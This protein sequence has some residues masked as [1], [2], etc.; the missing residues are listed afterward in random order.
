MHKKNGIQ[1]R[2][3]AYQILKSILINKK[4][5]K[6][7]FNQA[8]IKIKQSSLSYSDQAYIKYLVLTV[9][10]H[11]G[12]IDHI[13]NELVERPIPKKAES[14]RILLRL[15]A[16]QSLFLETPDYA[17]LSS[18]TECA[19]QIRELNVYKKFI[20][21]L[22]RRIIE[23][24]KQKLS[25]TDLT[26]NLPNWLYKNW[27]KTYGK[28]KIKA[29]CRAH[30]EHPPIDLTLK[31]PD[32]LTLLAQTLNAQILPSQGLRL[33]KTSQIEALKGYQEGLWW[34]QDVSS[35]LPVYILYPKKGEKILDVCSAPGGK[36]MQI[37]SKG[38]DLTALEQSK[39]RLDKM[40]E[41]FKRL[42]LTAH[43]IQAD[44][45][46]WLPNDSQSTHQD[47]L[48]EKKQSP[49]KNRD[50]IECFDSILLDAPC[51]A[52]GTLRR[53]PD[54]VWLKSEQD[55]Q[56]LQQKQ[57]KL[58]KQAQN[59]LKPGGKIVFCVCSLQFEET[60]FIRDHLNTFC[61]QLTLDPISEEEISSLF[62][63]EGSIEYNL[64]K[65]AFE[66]G[67]LRLMPY[68]WKAYGGMDGF[69]IMRMKKL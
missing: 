35:S 10:K 57:I 16:A 41:N 62:I 42:N 32:Q 63:K 15:S 45:L 30:I 59:W 13:I 61:P 29:L 25:N 1:T 19:K 20:H 9:L 21:A 5:L 43:F 56:R 69:F 11:L 38:V 31:N 68:F 23:Q 4:T 28:E 33:K 60:G 67:C 22:S 51:S 26:K 66:K 55:I 27:E 3:L 64:P 6:Q 46:N 44:A 54:V 2:K 36:A 18:M 8:R 53:S 40:K 58:L 50:L 37:A 34:V 47:Y 14:A 7:S 39:K 12:Q 24:G 52:T 49:T 65:E 48:S 17:I